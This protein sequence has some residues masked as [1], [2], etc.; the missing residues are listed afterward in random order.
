MTIPLVFIGVTILMIILGFPL[1]VS[2][3]IGGLG[4]MIVLE[5]NPGQT[6]PV[7]ADVDSIL[8]PVRKQFRGTR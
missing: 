5:I 3:G 4:M 8:E 7:G 2:F 1:F 6:R